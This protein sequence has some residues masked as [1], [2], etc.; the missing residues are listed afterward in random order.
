MHA[1]MC[2]S[3]CGDSKK[4]LSGDFG[5]FCQHGESDCNSDVSSADEDDLNCD[6]EAGLD[7]DPD[8]YDSSGGLSKWF[9]AKISC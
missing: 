1:H 2:C 5:N 6:Q 8:M 9:K 7:S 3:N 4:V